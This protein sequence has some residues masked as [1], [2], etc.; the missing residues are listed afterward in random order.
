MATASR[1]T[2]IDYVKT[3]FQIPILT[4]IHGE[5]TFETLRVLFNELKANAGDVSTTLGGGTLGYLG[6]LLSILEYAPVVP[7][8][9]FIRPPNPGPLVIP[10]GTTQ[11]A[12]T[13]MREDHAEVLRQH[14]EC[15]DVKA[16]LKSVSC[17]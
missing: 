5:P 13:R 17:N 7:G 11:H 6:L 3:Y 2:N 4:K 15:N 9:P 16:A 12:A 10:N 8:T 1:P 14:C